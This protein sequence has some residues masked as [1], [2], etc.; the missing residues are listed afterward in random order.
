M[1][2][3]I[4]RIT[5]LSL[6]RVDDGVGETFER[7]VLKDWDLAVALCGRNSE[8]LVLESHLEEEKVFEDKLFE[9]VI[10]DFFWEHPYGEASTSK[11]KSL[12]I[13]TYKNLSH[14]EF[15]SG[16][17]NN[18]CTDYDANISEFRPSLFVTCKSVD[19]FEGA[20]FSTEY[21][22]IKY[23]AEKFFSLFSLRDR[24]NFIRSPMYGTLG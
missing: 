21:G 5:Y 20:F 24:F 3:P 12:L 22:E 1:F 6:G 10:D 17:T 18:F 13:S 16:N 19:T 23:D 8:F 14:K 2:E 7:F 15:C 9:E 11:I 4:N